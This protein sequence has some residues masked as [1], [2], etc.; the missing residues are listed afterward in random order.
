MG[1]FLAG[2]PG[3]RLRLALAAKIWGGGGGRGGV[4]AACPSPVGFISPDQSDKSGPS[5]LPRSGLACVFPA[6]PPLLSC[7]LLEPQVAASGQDALVTV[8]TAKCLPAN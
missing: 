8:V 2:E 7:L 5:S 6:W 1:L 3:R 4:A